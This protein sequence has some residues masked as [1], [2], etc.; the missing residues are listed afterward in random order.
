MNEESPPPPTTPLSN[1]YPQSPVTVQVTVTRL[2]W[3]TSLCASDVIPAACQ[4]CVCHMA[5]SHVQTGVGHLHVINVTGRCSFLYILSD[6][7]NA[8][9]RGYSTALALYHSLSSLFVCMQYL[10]LIG[11]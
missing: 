1:P 5:V 2:T 9:S 8:D 11:A 3:Q 4:F 10:I 6:R 7:L